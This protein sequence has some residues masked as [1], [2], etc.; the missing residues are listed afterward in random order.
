MNKGKH[1]LFLV[2]LLFLLVS[3]PACQTTGGAV[4]VNMPLDDGGP[5]VGRPG[6]PPPHAP[7]HG[8]RKKYSYR[9]YP[10]A[11]VYFDTGRGLYFYLDH[12]QWRMSVSLPQE[13]KVRLGGGVEIEMDSDRPYTDF[14]AHKGKY[15]PG[16]MKRKE[17]EKKNRGW[18]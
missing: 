6:G 13:I 18:E 8:Y 16:K 1:P 14:D 2:G 11:Y 3:L 5:G 15:P 7:A 10:D 9:Y 17:K 4:S 12:D